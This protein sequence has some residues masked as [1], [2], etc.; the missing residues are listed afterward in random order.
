M[1]GFWSSTF[2]GGNSFEESVANTFTPNDGYSYE[3]GD[4][5]NDSTGLVVD[6]K[7]NNCCG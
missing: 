1:A 7:Q 3:R 5:V 6:S 2:G 4:L